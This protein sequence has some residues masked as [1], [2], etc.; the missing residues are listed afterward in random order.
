MAMVCVF[1]FLC[2]VSNIQGLTAHLSL[3]NLTSGLLSYAPPPF[4]P[5][6]WSVAVGNVIL[7]QNKLFAQSGDRSGA[8]SV[9]GGCKTLHPTKAPTKSKKPATATP[10]KALFL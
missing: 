10:N 5:R 3:F 9:G 6:S 1:K 2:H 4:P 8:F 7:Y